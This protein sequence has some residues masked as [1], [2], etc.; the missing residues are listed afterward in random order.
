MAAGTVVF[1]S[2]PLSSPLTH[3]A[4]VTHGVNTLVVVPTLL[5][6]LVASLEGTETSLESGVADERRHRGLGGG[7]ARSS[8]LSG[9][10]MVCSKTK[11]NT[12]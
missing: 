10:T 6:T 5:S 7:G 9:I 1:T 2:T 12:I 4:L 8:L 3:A 11:I